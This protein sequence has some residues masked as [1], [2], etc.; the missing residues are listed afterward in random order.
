MRTGSG[1]EPSI[2]THID[3]ATKRILEIQDKTAEVQHCTAW[4]ERYEKVHI[5]VTARTPA[6]DRPEDAQVVGAV[7]GRDTLDL[8]APASQFVKR[9]WSC[10]SGHK[11][12]PCRPIP[13]LH[14]LGKVGRADTIAAGE[15]G[16]RP[17][18]L[19][20]TVKRPRRQP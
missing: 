12:S 20:H 2:S 8:F 18:Q 10:F 7:S 3:V 17:R 1:D 16:D 5:A 6:R 11:S 14:C 15:I 19:E 4:F 9:R 13:V